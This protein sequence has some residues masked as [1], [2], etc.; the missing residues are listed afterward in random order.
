MFKLKKSEPNL[1]TAFL[2]GMLAGALLYSLYMLTPFVSEGYAFSWYDLAKDMGSSLAAVITL[3]ALYFGWKMHKEALKQN[4]SLSE[5]EYLD[6][7]DRLMTSVAMFRE[8]MK[9]VL[10]T[11]SGELTSHDLNEVYIAIDTAK[12][13]AHECIISNKPQ[14]DKINGEPYQR[15]ILVSACAR[16]LLQCELMRQYDP[17][18]MVFPTEESRLRYAES[19]IPCLKNVIPKKVTACDAFIKSVE[20][21]T[22]PQS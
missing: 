19:D 8:A 10:H 17:H 2:A 5:K 14:F 18:E 22:P 11:I 16:S 9:H 21:Q 4:E 3:M 15:Y 1:I 7:I 13:M 6:T 12:E 20:H